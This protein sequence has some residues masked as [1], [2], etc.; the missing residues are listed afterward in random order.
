MW[1][2]KSEGKGF[3]MHPQ[4]ALNPACTNVIMCE[5]EELLE[6]ELCVCVKDCY[7]PKTS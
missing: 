3:A 1:R 5:Y 7:K 2:V 4:Y 6:C